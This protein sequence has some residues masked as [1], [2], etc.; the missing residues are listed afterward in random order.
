M[1]FIFNRT[2]KPLQYEQVYKSWIELQTESF[3]ASKFL[4]QRALHFEITFNTEN[5][6]CTSSGKVSDRSASDTVGG[7]SQ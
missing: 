3:S 6:P 2:A 5:S 7:Q 1:L 4:L